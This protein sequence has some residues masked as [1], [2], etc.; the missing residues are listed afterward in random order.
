M[1][2]VSI[3]RKLQKMALYYKKNLKLSKN[4]QQIQICQKMQNKS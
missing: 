3:N 2:F 1:I 4:P